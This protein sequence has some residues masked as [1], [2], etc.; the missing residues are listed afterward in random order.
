MFMAF[1]IVGSLAVNALAHNMSQSAN[2]AGGKALK[3]R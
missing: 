2:Q 3:V 1:F